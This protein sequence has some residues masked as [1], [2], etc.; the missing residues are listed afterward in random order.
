MVRIFAFLRVFK[1]FCLFKR[2]FEDFMSFLVLKKRMKK[3]NIVFW[4]KLKNSINVE[5]RIYDYSFRREASLR[6]LSFAQ[7]FS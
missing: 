7:P 6:A 1:N 5:M 2:L 3:H 4:H